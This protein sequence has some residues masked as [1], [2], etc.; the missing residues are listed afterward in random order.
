MEALKFKRNSNQI[1]I[2]FQNARLSR[3]LNDSRK[4]KKKCLLTSSWTPNHSLLLSESC[5]FPEPF[6]FSSSTDM[7]IKILVITS[8]FHLKIKFPIKL[9]ICLINYCQLM[10]WFVFLKPTTSLQLISVDR[11]SEV[12]AISECQK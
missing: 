4:W 1:M 10:S 11:M 6:E 3:V 12:I 9:I 8:V 5:G 7:S 2:L